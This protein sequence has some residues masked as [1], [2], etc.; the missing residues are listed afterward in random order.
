MAKKLIPFSWYPYSWGLAGKSRERAKAEYELSGFELDEKLLEINADEYSPKEFQKRTFDLLF[1][2]NKISKLEH[3]RNLS[4]LIED[5]K[6][7]AIAL[8][9]LDYKENL[10]SENKYQKESAT[11]RGEAWVDV[12]RLEFD[13]KKST[14][15]SFELDWNDLFIEKLKAEGYEGPTDDSLVNQWFIG[16][17]KNIAMEEFDGVGNFN[18]DT[19]AN[20]E[21]LQRWNSAEPMSGGRKGHK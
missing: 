5:E 4:S 8:L 3:L 15:G 9:E 2:Y 6:Q 17:C 21:A 16:T 14:E 1:K 13:G 7:K 11:L 12:V 19:V 20:M 10:I 18:A